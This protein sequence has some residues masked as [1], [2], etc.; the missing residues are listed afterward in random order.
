MPKKS[1]LPPPPPPSRQGEPNPHK[2]AGP[3]QDPKLQK[4]I[5][6][7]RARMGEVYSWK[8]ENESLDIDNIRNEFAKQFEKINTAI[9]TSLSK[10]NELREKTETEFRTLQE[11]VTRSEAFEKQIKQTD[12]KGMM[13]DIEALKSKMQFLEES[14]ENMDLQ[15]VIDKLDKFEDNLKGLKSSIPLVIE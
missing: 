5:E 2:P 3:Q 6:I 13:R 8:K 10:N 9:K 7:L 11:L 1:K 12:L 4:E 14:F 15:K